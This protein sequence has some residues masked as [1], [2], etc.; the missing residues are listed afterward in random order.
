MHAL[1]RPSSRSEAA[2]WRTLVAAICPTVAAATPTNWATMSTSAAR[3]TGPPSS[4]MRSAAPLPA[5]AVPTIVGL[6]PHELT[7]RPARAAPTSHRARP[8]ATGM[9]N[10]AGPSPKSRTMYRLYSA[11][12]KLPKNAPVAAAP[13]S[14]Q[15]RVSADEA[16]AVDNLGQ[17]VL[18]LFDWRRRWLRRSNEH[19]HQCRPDE[20]ERIEQHRHRARDGLDEHAGHAGRGDVAQRAARLKPAVGLDKTAPTHKHRHDS[21]IGRVEE[22]RLTPD[23]KRHDQQVLEAQRTQSPGGGDTGQQRRAPEIGP[24][25]DRLSAQAVDPYA[26]Y[27]P[28]TRRAGRRHPRGRPFGAAWRQ[29]PAGQSAPAPRARSSVQNCETVSPANNLAKCGWCQRLGGT[30]SGRLVPLRA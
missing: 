11:A 2:A 23:Q 5:N 17:K 15:H 21:L 29:A 1:A 8:Q 6:T 3:S 20:R 4:G 14:A 13:P 12:K 27:R 25:H 16:E 22:H 7:M 18:S 26:G 28:T 19:Q 24:E 30:R 10:N 9:P